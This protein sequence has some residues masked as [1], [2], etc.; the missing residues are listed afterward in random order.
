M[1]LANKCSAVRRVGVTIFLR[2]PTIQC[3][4]TYDFSFSRFIISK[5]TDVS[6]FGTGWCQHLLASRGSDFNHH[7]RQKPST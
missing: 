5:L 7:R 1:L 4:Y 3:A 6:W 2:F